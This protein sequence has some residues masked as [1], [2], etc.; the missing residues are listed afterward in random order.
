ML[1]L[2]LSA[3]G[4]V[5]RPTGD[6]GRAAPSFTHDTAMPFA[7]KMLA[8]KRGEPVSDFNQTDEEDEMH[9]RVWRF[10]VA[11]HTKDWFYNIAVELQRT[12]IIAAIDSSFAVT[13]Y[14]DWLRRTP[15]ES[16]PVRFATVERDILAD[17]DTVPGTFVAICKV[18]QIDQQRAI[19]RD[20]L[21]GLEPEVRASVGERKAE[22]DAYIAWFVRALDYRYQSY[23]YALD[24]LLVETPNPRSIE[25]DLKLRLMERH[26]ARAKRGDFC[27]DGTGRVTV[28]S[29]FSIPSRYATQKI[30]NEVIAIK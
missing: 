8:R 9:N 10:L 29:R 11:E 21:G 19:G 6:F 3:A 20:S 4:C 17:L 24:H 5:E 2:L 23:D 1:A 22:N 15:Y 7:G 13:L 16:S 18:I 28:Q 30:D 12:R 14:Y 26:V 27:G 25:V